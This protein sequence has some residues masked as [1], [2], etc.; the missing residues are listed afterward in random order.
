MSWEL[1]M[2]II[3]MASAPV[4]SWLASK[5][6]RGKYDAEI[7]RLRAEVATARADADGKEL[8][9]ARLGNEIIM[10]N[11]VKPLETQIKRLNTN[12]TRFEKAVA[13]IPACPHNAICPVTS[14]LLSA[15]ENEDG[16][17]QDTKKQ[18]ND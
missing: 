18:V 15:C 7:E 11:I 16:P 5:L 13:K 9:N 17:E 12:V 2:A 6:T 1:I 14:E 3:G 4:A 10:N 8:A